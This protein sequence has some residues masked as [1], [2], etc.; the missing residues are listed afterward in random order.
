[1]SYLTELFSLEGKVVAAIGAGGVLAG[2]MA[3]AFAKAGAKVA[4]L[5]LNQARAGKR[6]RSEEHTSEL[7][8]H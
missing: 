8:S 7:Q 2:T 5:D 1:M 4:I 3:D 6:A